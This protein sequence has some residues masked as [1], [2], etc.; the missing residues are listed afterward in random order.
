MFE[1][2][3][4]KMEKKGGDLT[5]KAKGNKD[6]CSCACSC[7]EESVDSELD[8]GFDPSV[9][10]MHECSCNCAGDDCDS[11]SDSASEEP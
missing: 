7:P 3:S 4:K 5:T 6:R 1:I 11:I 9:D 8:A 10:G 2:K